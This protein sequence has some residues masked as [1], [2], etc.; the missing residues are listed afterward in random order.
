MAE[1]A[2]LRMDYMGRD[3]AGSV[4]HE[5]G[6]SREADNMVCLEVVSEDQTHRRLD[7]VM[8]QSLLE[9]NSLI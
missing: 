5:Q 1:A 7:R 6:N 2:I 4:V 9:S 3:I 8:L